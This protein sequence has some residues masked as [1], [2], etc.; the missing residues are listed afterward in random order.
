MKRK[1]IYLKNSD[2]I[3][4]IFK[5][6]SIRDTAQRRK[7]AELL[8]GEEDKHVTAEYV[9]KEISLSGN[10]VSL[11]TIYNTLKEFCEKNLICEI[12]LGEGVTYFDTN[13]KF[14]HHFFNKETKKIM[15]SDSN[16]FKN[17]KT[18]LIAGGKNKILQI[19]S[20]LKSTLFSGLITD[21][22]T[23]KNL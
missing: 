5:Q 4:Q 13:T 1:S 3:S 22:N 11:A 23:A 16:F 7:I 8:F 14:H 15:G 6:N 2:K 17:T 9:Y 19:K 18:V 12:N 20:V 21:E 10:K